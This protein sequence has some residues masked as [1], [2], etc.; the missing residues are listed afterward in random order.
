MMILRWKLNIGLSL[1]YIGYKG[2]FLW[3]S[4]INYF[5]RNMKSMIVSGPP[6]TTPRKEPLR[7]GFWK[8]CALNNLLLQQFL[9]I[10][11][12]LCIW[13]LKWPWCYTDEQDMHSQISQ[14]LW[15]VWRTLQGN[16]LADR[17]TSEHP[18]LHRMKGKRKIFYDN[19]RRSRKDFQGKEASGNNDSMISS[20]GLELHPGAREW[21]DPSPVDRRYHAWF[22]LQ[23]AAW[24]QSRSWG[25]LKLRVQQDA[26]LA[27]GPW[28]S[29]KG[30]GKSL[31]NSKQG[32]CMSEN[33][34]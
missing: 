30:S 4:D 13:A 10:Q 26:S 31:M 33:V 6:N 16:F 32:N 19:F 12:L 11:H 28:I 20:A 21:A 27:W 22:S 29:V 18:G 7:E 3:L 5:P 1:S 25:D 34:S 9:H 8:N 15:G 24:N 17:C 14:A 2:V 23:Q